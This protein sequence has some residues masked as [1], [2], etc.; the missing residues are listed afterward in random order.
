MLG[1]FLAFSIIVLLGNTV[2]AIW[3]RNT[4]SRIKYIQKGVNQFSSTGYENKIVVEGD[5]EIAELGRAIEAL[6]LEIKENEKTKQEMFQNVSH[7]LKTPIAVIQSYAEAIMDG[8]T[9]VEDAKVI[10]KQSEKLQAKVRMLLELSKIATLEVKE[11]I[12]KYQTKR[13][14]QS[15]LV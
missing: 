1:T 2:V 4:T 13:Y 5:D 14:H 6:R 12:R 9:E 3:S 8:T 10:I 7:D 11:K 15:S